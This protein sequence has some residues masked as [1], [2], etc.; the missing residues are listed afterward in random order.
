MTLRGSF[1]ALRLLAV[2]L[3]ALMLR[4]SDGTAATAPD[5]RWRL[6]GPNAAELPRSFRL[7]TDAFAVETGTALSR[8]GLETLRASASGEPSYT[9]LPMLYARLREAAGAGAPIYLVDLRQES[10]GY[11]NHAYP[12]SWHKE[13]N[14]ANRGRTAEQVERDERGRLAALIGSRVTFEPMGRYDTEHF[15]P[16]TLDVNAVTTEREAAERIG[17]QYF[18]IAATDQA[19]PSDA[20]IDSFVAL[21][22]S[23]PETAWLHFH[24]H[25]G[26]GRTTTFLIFYDLMKNPGLP[27]ETIAARQ[28]ALG[29]SDI[30]HPSGEGWRGDEQE[31]RAGVVRAFY[32]Y[33]KEE[34]KAGFRTPWSRWKRGR[35]AL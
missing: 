1:A 24:C 4:T 15:E 14:W 35:T 12:V 13:R 28:Y 16:A 10:H 20:A 9:A 30:L 6:D 31:K 26:H 33:V 2:L 32:Q 29:G 18:R 34:G 5:G 25:A 7:M 22:A 23:L 3:A 11:V 27:L 17:F 21:A 19:A 8:D